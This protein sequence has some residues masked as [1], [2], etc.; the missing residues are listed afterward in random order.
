MQKPSFTQVK[1]LD[2]VILLK[3]SYSDLLEALLTTPRLANDASFWR[4]KLAKDFPLRSK[5]LVYPEHIEMKRKNP[6]KLYEIIMQ[7]AKVIEYFIR[8]DGFEEM[9]EMEFLEKYG[10]KFSEEATIYPLLR[11]DLVHVKEFGDYRNDGIFIWDGQ[12]LLALD[13]KY[14]DYGAWSKEI[15]FP[16]FDWNHYLWM[17]GHNN[18]LW[19]SPEKVEEA[20]RNFDE[21]KQCT[22]LRDTYNTFT[23]PLHRYASSEKY[24]KKEF[25]DYVRRNPLLD[26]VEEDGGFYEDYQKEDEMVLVIGGDYA[27]ALPVTFQKI[28]DME[29]KP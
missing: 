5:Y 6:R 28:L 19:L 3:L 11:G 24:S 7:K 14:D 25:E 13:Y 18:I 27:L 17:N 20:I 21:E 22:Q 16:G 2:S 15:S 9:E 26:W 10:Q 23:I 12:K 1:D 29:W 8:K 4:N